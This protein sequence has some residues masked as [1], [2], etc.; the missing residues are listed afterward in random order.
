MFAYNDA[1]V[2]ILQLLPSSVDLKEPTTICKFPIVVAYHLKSLHTFC[3]YCLPFVTLSN[4]LWLLLI[5]CSTFKP[6]V[7]VAYHM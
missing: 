2:I 1:I 5:I 7:V 4:P 3:G 6:I